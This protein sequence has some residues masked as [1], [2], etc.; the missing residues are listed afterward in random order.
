MYIDAGSVSA[1]ITSAT[2]RQL[3]E[4]GGRPA[5]RATT[6]HRHDRQHDGEPDG[7]AERRPKAARITYTASLTSA[8]AG[9]DR[10][11]HADNGASDHD[12]GRRQTAARAPLAA[13][14]DDVVPMRPACRS[15][16]PAPRGGNFENLVV[17]R[18]AAATDHRHD[19]H[20][21]GEPDGDAE[22]DRRRHRSPT[23]RRS[24]AR[25]GSD[26][27]G[28]ADNGASDHHRRRRQTSGIVSVA[29]PSDDV[30]PRTASMTVAIT[31]TAG[32][33]FENLVVDRH[34][35]DHRSPTRSTPRR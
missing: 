11:G 23:P 10:D 32:G 29:A 16:S 13:Q 9:S 33:N 14:G 7:H 3:R 5:R 27:H 8:A 35:G 21:D 22:R 12:R 17:D 34:G 31:G 20:H 28:H 26:G 2:R 4:P 19:R 25:P 6:D 15:R 1:T 18:P 30:V 24:P